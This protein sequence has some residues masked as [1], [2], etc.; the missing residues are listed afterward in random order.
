MLSL[1]LEVGGIAI[2]LV[3]LAL[4]DPALS[5]AAVGALMLGL[6]VHLERR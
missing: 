3:C 5:G 4:V 1:L 6:G 2:L